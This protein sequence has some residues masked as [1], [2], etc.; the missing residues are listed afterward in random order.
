MNSQNTPV[1]IRLWHRDF[2]LMSVAN[3]LLTAAVYMLVP[4]MPGWL[5]DTQGFSPQETGVAMGVFGFGLFLMGVFVSF[6]VQHYRRNVV[7]ICA[8]LAMAALIG[9]LYYVEARRSEFVSSGL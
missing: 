2:W 3:L 4:T 6:L 8:I 5:L 1:H 9:F 7:C